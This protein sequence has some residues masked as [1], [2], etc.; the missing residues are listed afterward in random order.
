M[1]T[2]NAGA[3]G[4]GLLILLNADRLLFAGALVTALIM[5][6]YLGWLAV[7]ATF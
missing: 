3:R 6:S 2:I 1:Q 7:P 5:S 4:V